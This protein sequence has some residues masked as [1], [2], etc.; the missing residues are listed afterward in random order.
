MAELPEE[1]DAMEALDTLSNMLQNKSA[2]QLAEIHQEIDKEKNTASKA[3][4]EQSGLPKP[5][6]HMICETCQSA[7]WFGSR[8]YLRCFCEKMHTITYDSTNMLDEISVCDG[9]EIG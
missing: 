2:E 1:F 4:L 6:K 8:N 5:K 7:M 3:L 9:N